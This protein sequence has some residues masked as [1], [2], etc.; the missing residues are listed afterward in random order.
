MLTSGRGGF[1]M[2]NNKPHEDEPSEVTPS[3]NTLKL[4]ENDMSKTLNLSELE[5]SDEDAVLDSQLKG[6]TLAGLDALL[7]YAKY[8]EDNNLLRYELL[9][10]RVDTYRNEVS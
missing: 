7:R 2:T 5:L 8:L 9:K 3:N 10:Q 6:L 4:K 1:L